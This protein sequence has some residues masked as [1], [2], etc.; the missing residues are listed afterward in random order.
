MSSTVKPRR[1]QPSAVNTPIT[2]H[3]LSNTTLTKESTE[4]L[5]STFI[6]EQEERQQQLQLDAVATDA[7]AATSLAQLKR[8][9]RDLR[10]LPP[11]ETAVTPA[12]TPAPVTPKT[13]E[14][15]HKKFD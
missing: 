7:N 2:T 1:I 13:E 4:R 15:K 10:G 3:T 11:L 8:I 14:G 12:V 5:L 6:E 9:Q